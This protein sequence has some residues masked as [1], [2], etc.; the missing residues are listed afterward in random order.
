MNGSLGS[1]RGPFI[2]CITGDDQA[3]T[4]HS[5]TGYREQV[6]YSHIFSPVTRSGVLLQ[7]VF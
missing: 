4:T 5:G 6:Y 7:I 1:G 2:A 3:A